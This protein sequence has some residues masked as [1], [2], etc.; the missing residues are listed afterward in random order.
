[1][2]ASSFPT[3][4]ILRYLLLLLLLRLAHSPQI[5]TLTSSSLIS[6][7][8]PIPVP[9]TFIDKVITWLPPPPCKDPIWIL[10]RECDDCVKAKK[11]ICS[12]ALEV[13]DSC[14]HCLTRDCTTW[15]L[16]CDG[17]FIGLVGWFQR[18]T[19][20]IRSDLPDITDIVAQGSVDYALTWLRE[21]DFTTIPE[22]AAL[23]D[24]PFP[25]YASYAV[26]GKWDRQGARHLTANVVF[27]SRVNRT[28]EREALKTST[29]SAS[30]TPPPL[31][32]TH[33]HLPPPQPALRLADSALHSPRRRARSRAVRSTVNSGLSRLRRPSRP[34]RAH[35][36]PRA[37]SA[38]PMPMSTWVRASPAPPS[39]KR[40]RKLDDPD[41]RDD[42]RSR[43]SARSSRSAEDRLN[44]EQ[45]AAAA[46][47]VHAGGDAVRWAQFNEI[48]HKVAYH[49]S[50]LAK[51][52]SE[53]AQWVDNNAPHASLVDTP[54]D[55]AYMRR[56]IMCADIRASNHRCARIFVARADTRTLNHKP[57]TVTT[58]RGHPAPR[59]ASHAS[60]LPLF[61]TTTTTTDSLLRLTI[62]A[63][64]SL[65][66]SRNVFPMASSSSTSAALTTPPS[67][68]LDV[69]PMKVPE[70]TKTAQISN[71][72]TP[73]CGSI[74]WTLQSKCD[75]CID[76]GTRCLGNG[77][78]ACKQCSS[79]FSGNSCT[80]YGI[81]G[82]GALILPRVGFVG[83]FLGVGF[84]VIAD[85]PKTTEIVA[86]GAIDYILTWLAEEDF[87]IAPGCKS[88]PSSPFPH[89]RSY[90][91]YAKW[92]RK[93]AR[94]LAAA[95]VFYAGPDTE[96][97]TVLGS[98]KRWWLA[99][100]TPEEEHGW[101]LRIREDRKSY[102]PIRKG[103]KV[104]PAPAPAPRKPAPAPRKPAPAPRKPAP[105][106]RKP[107]P[108]PRKPAP[109]P[110]SSPTTATAPASSPT[111]ATAL[112]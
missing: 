18:E 82:D 66:T 27:R 70:G 48:T 109:A 97:I 22:A 57:G 25:N 35:P 60:R 24:S 67:C 10:D 80:M 77:I 108:A 86:Q 30:K 110:A 94:A 9:D 72:A 61:P 46:R 20:H 36:P 4:A 47:T 104:L 59:L 11:G 99:M 69:A 45:F 33:R 12:D 23:F 100:P 73:R 55:E 43:K 2:F 98:S 65:P 92:D 74:R 83:W 26:F 19:I 15:G 89:I 105:A 84:R 63:T 29:S 53:L 34:L 6:F 56:T 51:T 17:A 87:E 21:Q 93:Q 112:A 13:D 75:D 39:T 90:P 37:L 103:V 85:L 81:R 16:R 107:A 54:S 106:P 28:R 32:Q 14:S 78:G 7:P 64:Y 1:M 31:T 71:H 96:C 40:K 95:V 76:C 102:R 50:S 3:I 79:D 42:S 52:S 5:S 49:A 44:L 68:P 58:S 62:P 41:D 88:L 101:F 8:M 91:A 38:P 111:T